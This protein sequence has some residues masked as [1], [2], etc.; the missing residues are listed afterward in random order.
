M[1]AK[2][3]P[4]QKT[5]P[6]SEKPRSAPVRMKRWLI[7][8]GG[9]LALLVFVFVGFNALRS[10]MIAKFFASN[11]PPA[12]SVSV[13]DVKSEVLPRLLVGIGDLAAVHQVDVTTDVNG[14]VMEILF[15]PGAS[16][17]AGDPLIQI[18]DAPD[19]SD[20]A[21]F[22]AQTLAAQLALD[23]AKT[24]AAK[25]FGP[26]ATVDQAQAGYDQANA[27]VAKT[28][29]V[30]SQKRI[31][32]PFDGDLGV[33]K[34][35]LGQYLSAGTQ[36]VSLT[37]L[38]KLYLNFTATEKDRAI[39]NVGQTVRVAVDAYPNR[40]FEG[41]ITTI[42]PQITADTRNVRIQATLENPGRILKPGMFATTKV[43]LPPE[44]AVATVPE[45]SID[46]T[47]YGDSV[48][49]IEETKADDGTTG[50]KATRTFVKTGDRVN[51]R[52]VIKSGVKAG[53]RVV[54]AGQL[55]LQSGSAVTISA[56]PPPP[57]PAQPPRN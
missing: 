5:N 34:V 7:I 28:E 45:T 29:A 32:A 37:D 54:A 23:R 42:E 9:A 6:P 48:Y 51:G 38:S 55:K 24:L 35:E 11:K 21:S 31:K 36:I 57:I 33:R 13:A 56:D 3:S 4:S 41:K 52:A 16:V 30:I 46:Y 17:K 14:R 22:K 39:L 19:Q 2:T 15:T 40:T 43:E 53:D 18:F 44:D 10:Y 50:F 26:Q 20:L 27:A 25:Q 8:V 49:L 47:L 1:D 12:V